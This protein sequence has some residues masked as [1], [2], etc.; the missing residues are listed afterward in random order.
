MV[1]AAT[2]LPGGR[3]RVAGSTTRPSAGRG[4]W[5]VLS[6]SL[7]ALVLSGMVVPGAAAATETPASQSQE[8]R[9]LDADTAA[10]FSEEFVPD[11]L[12]RHQI[13]G[14]SVAVVAGDEQ[15]FANGYGVADV[16]SERPVHVDQTAFSP[17]SVGKLLTATAVMQLVEDQ[18]IDLNTDVNEYLDGFQVD[19]T[20]PGQPV[21]TAHLL[22]HTAG[23]AAR[24]S[25]TGAASAGDVR[26]LGTQLAEHL[27]ERVRPP[28]ERAVYSNYGMG[29]AGYLVE[30]RSG[31][32]FHQYV[33]EAILR[34]LDMDR[35]TF[36]QPTPDPIRENQAIGHRLEDGRQIPAEGAE[37]GHMPPH[38]AGFRSTAPDMARFMRAMLDDGA[39]I[40]QP[41]SAREMRRQQFANAPGT[42]GMGYGFQ[43]YPSD[44]QRV[45]VH[46]GAIPGSFAVL[47]MVPEQGI[48][49]YASYNG[50]DD[51]AA[52]SAWSLVDAFMGRFASSTPADTGQEASSLPDPAQYEGTYR[53]LQLDD[54]TDLGKLAGLMNTVTVTAGKNELTTTGA[55]AL[56][57]SQT[58]Q[59]DQVEGGLFRERG[60]HQTIRFGDDGLLTTADPTQPLERLAWYETPGPHLVVVGVSLFVQVAVVVGW[61]VAHYAR[62]LRG[63]PRRAPRLAWVP[64]WA[65]AI[66]T[67]ASAAPLTAMFADFAANQAAFFHGASPLLTAI[68]TLPLLAAVAAAGAAVTTT[69]AWKNRWFSPMGRV[70]STAVVVAAAAYLTLAF[71]Y[72]VPAVP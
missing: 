40:L 59:W 25:G 8:P 55:A 9:P 58:R 20:Y 36:A 45:I 28:G 24:D 6:G 2:L 64:G 44:G 47:A 22:T 38:G 7:A 66:L 65:T 67:V 30:E 56:G 32:P 3:R 41:E 51:A 10:E 62:R 13:P 63:R 69:L 49:V 71:A 57:P 43:E 48:G 19:D 21:T 23:F 33:D 15:V 46:R 29:L 42:P 60:G 53:N 18:Q 72:N 35:T 16:A 54:T 50:G 4:P 27:P 14:A 11:Q 12:E 1:L 5:R 70:V 17:A 34:P 52:D 61:P 31:V 39:G 26:P 68:G 37:H